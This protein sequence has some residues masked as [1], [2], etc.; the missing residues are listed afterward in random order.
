MTT[1]TAPELGCLDLLRPWLLDI[2]APTDPALRQAR[3][4]R[5]L[6]ET[7]AARLRPHAED[8]VTRMHTH[9][10]TSVPWIRKDGHY[11]ATAVT[12]A[13]GVLET[14][15]DAAGL[16]EAGRTPSVWALLDLGGEQLRRLYDLTEVFEEQ[17]DFGHTAASTAALVALQRAAADR[18][19]PIGVGLQHLDYLGPVPRP[20][21][22]WD[23]HPLPVPLAAVTLAAVR[24]GAAVARSAVA[25]DELTRPDLTATEHAAADTTQEQRIVQSTAALDLTTLAVTALCRLLG[26]YVDGHWLGWIGEV[27][28]AG[29][30]ATT[31]LVEQEQWEG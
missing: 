13:L 27:E 2:V 24:A 14:V 4:V 31:A 9:D 15:L 8:V 16:L 11:M 1:P 17:P 25:V 12:A 22:P 3:A 21:D 20:T 19:L 6:A 30:L 10:S 18:G 29:R 26:T 7:L 28:L 23:H 5:A